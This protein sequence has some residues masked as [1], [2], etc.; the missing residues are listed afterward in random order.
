VVGGACGGC[1]VSGSSSSRCSGMRA[2]LTIGCGDR[3]APPTH[4]V[5]KGGSTEYVGTGGGRR[6]APG[7]NTCEPSEALDAGMDEKAK[8]PPEA[9]DKGMDGKMGSA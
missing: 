7:E 2:G 1:G 3:A 5:P 4:I 8:L 9:L 6:E